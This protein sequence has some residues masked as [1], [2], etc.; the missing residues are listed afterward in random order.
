MIGA[1]GGI[2]PGEPS[3]EMGYYFVVVVAAVAEGVTDCVFQ[4]V[5]PRAVVG[6]DVADLGCSRPLTAKVCDG[7]RCQL[8]SGE[9]DSFDLGGVA[10]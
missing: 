4:R 8:A 7:L 3:P 2:Y 5:S 9:L 6:F 1:Q 10:T